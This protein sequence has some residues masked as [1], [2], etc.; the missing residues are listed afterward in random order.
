M[1]RKLSYRHR[2]VCTIPYSLL[3]FLIA[4]GCFRQYLDN[5]CNQKDESF[6]NAIKHDTYT[7][8]Y[9]AESY[10]SQAFVWGE[11]KEGYNYWYNRSKW[12]AEYVR[13]KVL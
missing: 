1:A 9:G 12:Y 11:T 5:C 4:Y 10:F 2:L 3:H 8:W 13:T 6:V 7:E